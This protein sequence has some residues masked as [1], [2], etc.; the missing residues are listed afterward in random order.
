MNPHNKWV[1]ITLARHV[2]VVDR[3][4]ASIYGG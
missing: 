1:P 4:M 3:G 2:Q